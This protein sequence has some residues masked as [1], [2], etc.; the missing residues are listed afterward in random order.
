MPTI[1]SLTVSDTGDTSVGIQPNQWTLT[2]DCDMDID[3]D[4]IELFRK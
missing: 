3:D 2:F 4:Y 1:H